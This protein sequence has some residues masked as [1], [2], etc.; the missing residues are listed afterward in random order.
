MLEVCE[1]VMVV[2][3]GAGVCESRLW[4][5][6]RAHSWHPWYHDGA[7][8]IVV[9]PG[10]N[11]LCADTS[12]AGVLVLAGHASD[13]EPVPQHQRLGLACCM[14]ARQEGAEQE[15]EQRGPGVRHRTRRAQ[16][17]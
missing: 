8:T 13:R 4:V 2:W 16:L 5:M 10:V 12:V 1:Y 17:G 11:V 14:A 6:V 15:Q 9:V 3:E 7:L